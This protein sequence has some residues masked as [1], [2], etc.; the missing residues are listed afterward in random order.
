MTPS[1]LFPG[2]TIISHA[3]PVVR[4]AMSAE[5]VPTDKSAITAAKWAMLAKVVLRHKKK[6]AM[7]ARILAIF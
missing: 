6:S 2:N 5:N 4:L 1:L 3:I 7:D